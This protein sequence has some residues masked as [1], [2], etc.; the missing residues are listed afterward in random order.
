[1]KTK[2]LLNHHL[3]DPFLTLSTCLNQG[4]GCTGDRCHILRY[5]IVLRWL[6]SLAKRGVH[7]NNLNYQR[8]CWTSR[9]KFAKFMC[10]KSIDLLVGAMFSSHFL[11]KRHASDPIA[12]VFVN[13][14]N[15]KM[16]APKPNLLVPKGPFSGE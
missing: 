9:C 2:N 6:I 8:F 7:P 11:L 12:V 13:G 15:L 4:T 1:M 10:S 3:V 16:M 5:R 14:W